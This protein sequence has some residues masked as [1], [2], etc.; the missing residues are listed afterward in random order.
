[1]TPLIVGAIAAGICLVLYLL[2]RLGV[3]DF[4][5]KTQ[6]RGSG[7]V[8]S[9]VLG[10]AFDEV[11]HPVRHEA[12][13]ELQRQ[14]TVPAPSPEADGDPLGVGLTNGARGKHVVIELDQWGRPVDRIGAR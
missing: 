12:Q 7:S 4:S 10:A 6:K 8:G 14:A 9:G 3:V 1:V 5:D 11:F 2:H 13:Q